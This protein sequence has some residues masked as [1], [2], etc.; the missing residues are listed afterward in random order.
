MS[1]GTADALASLNL[2]GISS[3]T[4]VD[5]DAADIA[6]ADDGASLNAIA[7]GLTNGASMSFLVQDPATA[8][9]AN[10]A[11]LNLAEDVSVGADGDNELTVS[12]ADALN[13]ITNYDHAGGYTI[14]DDAAAVSG[15]SVEILGD[16][17][18]VTVTGLADAAQGVTINGF[19]D[20][21]GTITFSV[22]DLA[23]ALSESA[24]DLNLADSVSVGADGDN[25]LTVSEADALNGITNYD[26]AGG[27]TISDDAAAVSGSSVEILGD[28]DSV[29]VTGLADAAQGVTING[30]ED[31][32]GTITFSVEDLATALSE[33][34]GDLNLADSVSVGADG[35]NELTV[36]EADA[37]NGI[38]N[39]DHAGG[40]TI[41]DDAAAVSGSSVEILETLIL[42]P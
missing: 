17:D 1:T 6:N 26:H 34:A 23:T 33:S 24:G 2:A 32:I 31:A 3:I 22:E 20:A 30:F 36:S 35:D 38:T 16:S 42:L 13:G 28:S 19:E 11:G 18:S 29:T 39:Y 37:L 5:A 40:Y 4:L 12:E 41:S 14:S 15:S 9:A 21:I 10:A 7:G 8:L 25:E 27:Y